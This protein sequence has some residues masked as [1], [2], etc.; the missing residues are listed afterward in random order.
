LASGQK[1]PSLIELR[2]QGQR[3]A[4]CP[5]FVVI[6]WSGFHLNKDWSGGAME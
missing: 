2:E 6:E 1:F 3:L 4:D 5:G